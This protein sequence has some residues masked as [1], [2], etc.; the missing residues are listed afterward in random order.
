VKT[1]FRP[2]IHEPDGAQFGK[3]QAIGVRPVSRTTYEARPFRTSHFSAQRLH[4]P[5][6]SA[7]DVAFAFFSARDMKVAGFSPAGASA[8]ATATRSNPIF[9]CSSPARCV[10][11][12]H[13]RA[14][15]P[16]LSTAL[17]F[18]HPDPL[19]AKRWRYRAGRFR[20]LNGRQRYAGA[21]FVEV[22]DL[23]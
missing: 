14:L 15:W 23:D 22:D 21:E 1:A 18:V 17:P 7:E 10:A 6:I 13:I 19:L 11:W 4:V 5:E 2:P 20:H 3:N 8:Q 12:D 16:T 9:R